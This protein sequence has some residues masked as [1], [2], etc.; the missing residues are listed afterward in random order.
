MAVPVIFNVD[1]L[2]QPKFTFT[3]LEEMQ[4]KAALHNVSD[5]R[6]WH[7]RILL[8]PLAG[9]YKREAM[10]AAGKIFDYGYFHSSADYDLAFRFRRAGFKTMLC[11]DTFVHHDHDR[12]TSDIKAIDDRSRDLRSAQRDFQR[13]YQ[14]IDG[15]PDGS[16]YEVTMLN[17]LDV[18]EFEK[19]EPIE[20][21]GVDV[22]CGAPVLEMK[23]KLREAGL[24]NVNLS[25]FT[26]DPKY[27]FDLKTFCS[28]DVVVDRPQYIAD[29]F[30]GKLFDIILVGNPINGY[31][32]FAGFLRKIG[33][34]LKPDGH[35]FLKIEELA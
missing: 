34:K 33:S 18:T 26:T 9:V 27:W 7:E 15:W 3:T 20:I 5:P 2:E 14:G 23:N 4:E 10:D 21:L 11:K 25:A 22:R 13:K 19:K 35:L 1:H 29:H 6:L 12:A 16:N 8:E 31:P 17:M 24:F 28:G 30:S 32:E